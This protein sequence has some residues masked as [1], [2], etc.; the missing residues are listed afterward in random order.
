MSSRT[1]AAHLTLLR[2]PTK[3]RP[4]IIAECDT[5]RRHQACPPSSVAALDA[6]ASRS[7]SSWACLSRLYSACS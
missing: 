7:R 2:E 5:R 4:I 1:S 6:A 3:E